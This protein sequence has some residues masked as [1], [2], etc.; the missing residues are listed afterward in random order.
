LALHIHPQ[1]DDSRII[2]DSA[3]RANC[4]EP[5]KSFVGNFMYESHQLVLIGKGGRGCARG[6]VKFIEDV[7]D[8][9][10][11]GLF[12]DAQFGRDASIRPAS[13]N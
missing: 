6:D 1:I 13:R 11:D 10:G 12:A 4:A 9:A 8:V 7:T 5:T 2:W 3:H